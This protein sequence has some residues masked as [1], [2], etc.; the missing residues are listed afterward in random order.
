VLRQL[1]IPLIRKPG[2]GLAINV[3][4]KVDLEHVVENR[5]GNLHWVM[6]PDEE[7][8]D[9]ANTCIVRMVKPWNEYVFSNATTPILTETDGCSSFSQ[10]L[11]RVRSLIR[12][13]RNILIV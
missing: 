2:Q 6:R 5:M 3:L 11:E 10:N 1:K 9:F 8:P 7:A 4:V 13:M 12:P